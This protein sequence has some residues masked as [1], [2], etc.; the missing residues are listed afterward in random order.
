MRLSRILTEQTLSPGREVVLN[1]AEGRYVAQVLRM[2]A[3]QPLILFDGSG[4]DFEAELAQ[5]DRRGC[6]VRVIR[7]VS[8]EQPP[9]LKLHLGIGISRG[10]R[11]DFAIQKSVE[12]GVMAITPLLTERGTVRLK[13]ERLEKRL[14]HWRG[15]INS[16]CEQSGRS[17]VPELHPPAALSQWL[18]EHPQGLLLYHKAGQ[19]LADCPAPGSQLHLLIGPEGGLSESERSLAQS[20]GFIA[21][22]LGPRV[23]RTETAPIAA[24]AAIQMLWGDLR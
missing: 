9:R 3:G 8:R 18:G 17:L 13:A 4:I 23:L 16:A 7:E 20:V 14:A 5:C 10:E 22:R 6:T 2:R 11:M 12:L 15:V 19:T 21:V 1:A 24:L